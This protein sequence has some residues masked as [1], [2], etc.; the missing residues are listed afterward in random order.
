MIETKQ[1]PI[2]DRRDFD[3][4]RDLFESGWQ[5]SCILQMPRTQRCGVGRD[6]TESVNWT[7]HVFLQRD[8]DMRP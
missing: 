5:V 1:F 6:T 2:S 4:L 3:V 8:I 7:N